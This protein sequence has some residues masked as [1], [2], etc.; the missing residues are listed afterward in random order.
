[1]VM[2]M[3]SLNV[4]RHFVQPPPGVPGKKV[5]GMG[6]CWGSLAFF[7]RVSAM[8]DKARAC[9]WAVF[10]LGYALLPSWSSL[11]HVVETVAQLVAVLTG[12]LAGHA[13]D[14]YSRQKA[15]ARRGASSGA[16]GEVRGAGRGGWGRGD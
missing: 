5:L 2:L 1:M 16:R 11:G 8:P 7:M 14:Y 12:E 9:T 6:V 13:T 3:V 4:Y 15:R 10:C